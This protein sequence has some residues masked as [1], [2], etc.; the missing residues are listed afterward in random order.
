MTHPNDLTGRREDGSTVFLVKMLEHLICFF[1]NVK[2]LSTQII[3]MAH[4]RFL[5]ADNTRSGPGAMVLKRNK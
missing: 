5:Q 1:Y 3:R 4:E 2:R